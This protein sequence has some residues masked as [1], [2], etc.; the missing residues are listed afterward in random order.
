MT[1]RS[2]SK[3]ADVA[4]KIE[5]GS[6]EDCKQPK[7]TRLWREAK[8]PPLTNDAYDERSEMRR[9][10]LKIKQ[11]E[12]PSRQRPLDFSDN[13]PFNDPLSDSGSD[14]EVRSNTETV[15][16]CRTEMERECDGLAELRDQTLRTVSGEGRPK[17]G[18]RR[19]IDRVEDA[20]AEEAPVK[21]SQAA[22]ERIRADYTEAI[23][24]H[25]KP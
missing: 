25:F 17:A 11:E 4:V 23:R 16:E 8:L 7:R 18:M 3:D 15:S 12:E 21:A 6:D 9:T 1:K 24:G 10:G 13:D 22:V 14:F 5:Y 2:A 19:Q 20:A